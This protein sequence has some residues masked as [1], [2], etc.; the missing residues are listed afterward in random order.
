MG[1][2]GEPVDG[3]DEEG[4]AE[5]LGEGD[6]VTAVDGDVLGGE[7]EAFGDVPAV[8]A[9]GLPMRGDAGAPEFDGVVGDAGWEEERRCSLIKCVSLPGTCRK[10]N[11]RYCQA[12][13]T[14]GASPIGGRGN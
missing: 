4:D 7:V 6:E 3:R 12:F 1:E 13:D 11:G 9:E 2:A 5:V 8:E 10:A 14:F